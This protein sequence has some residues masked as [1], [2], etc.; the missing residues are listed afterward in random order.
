MRYEGEGRTDVQYIHTYIHTYIP[1]YIHAYIHTYLPTYLPTGLGRPSSMLV[2]EE[3]RSQ[4]AALHL[5]YEMMLGSE[6]VIDTIQVG[7][8]CREVYMSLCMYVCMY[9]CT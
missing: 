5:L 1:T 3:L 6:E 9:V 4:R 8:V 2:R 7:E